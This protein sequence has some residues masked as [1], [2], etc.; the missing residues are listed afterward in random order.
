MPQT[1][2]ETGLSSAEA[3]RRLK[4]FGPNAVADT[5]LNPNFSLNGRGRSA[6]SRFWI[7]S[8]GSSQASRKTGIKRIS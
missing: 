7:N 6:A 2:A 1:N 5:T 4:Q 3:S 8:K